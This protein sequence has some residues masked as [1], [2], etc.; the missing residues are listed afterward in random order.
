MVY[1]DVIHYDPTNPTTF[2]LSVKRGD[3]LLFRGYRSSS[4][5][6]NIGN[7]K[8]NVFSKISFENNAYTITHVYAISHSYTQGY[9]VLDADAYNFLYH[10][11]F[12][13]GGASIY[14]Y[15][16]VDDYDGNSNTNIATYKSMINYF[17]WRLLDY[18]DI[19]DEYINTSYETVNGTAGTDYTLIKVLPSSPANAIY[20]VG[21]YTGNSYAQGSYTDLG[22]SSTFSEDKCI[23]SGYGNSQTKIFPET[24]YNLSSSICDFGV[25]KAGWRI[26][27]SPGQYNYN[28]YTRKIVDMR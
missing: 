6:T 12:T 2:N 25:A 8:S 22:D 1:A 15:Y 11:Y 20:T 23:T 19:K 10:P 26:Y 17:Q 4:S 9:N 18:K 27:T 5:G 24:G 16:A 13:T 14:P 7:P 28:L 21:Y 3:I